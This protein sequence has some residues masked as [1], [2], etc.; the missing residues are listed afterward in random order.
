ME[1][2]SHCHFQVSFRPNAPIADRH[3]E[4]LDHVQRALMSVGIDARP[5]GDYELGIADG[6]TVALWLFIGRDQ[7]DM[8]LRG[9]LNVALTELLPNVTDVAF[10]CLKD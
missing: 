3:E 10:T 4:I 6:R 5:L 8:K 1:H 7:N 9:A 2:H